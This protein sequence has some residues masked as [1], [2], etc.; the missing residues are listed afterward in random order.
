MFAYAVVDT[1]GSLLLAA[2]RKRG[3]EYTVGIR[4]TEASEDPE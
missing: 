3:A 1:C 4:L 2:L